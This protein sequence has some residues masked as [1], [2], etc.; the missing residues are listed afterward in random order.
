MSATAHASVRPAR[1]PVVSGLPTI[2]V[3][4][5]PAP[6]RGFVATVIACALI[7][8]AGLAIVFALNTAMVEGAYQIREQQVLLNDLADTRNILDEEIAQAS[9][10]VALRARAEELG[11]EPATDIRHVDLGQGVVSGGSSDST[12]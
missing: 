12:E 5:S 3:V 7:F 2:Q 9:T 8:C 11:L 4:P 10:A 6:V 1:R